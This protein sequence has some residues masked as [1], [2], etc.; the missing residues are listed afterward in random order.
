MRILELFFETLEE[1]EKLTVDVFDKPYYYHITTDENV[2]SILKNGL[3]CSK[4]GYIYIIDIT[5][6]DVECEALK[7]NWLLL[8]HNRSK[9]Y[10]LIKINSKGLT[11]KKEKD[12]GVY[13]KTKQ[14][15]IDKKHLQLYAVYKYKSMADLWIE[16]HKKR[17]FEY[18]ERQRQRNEIIL[19]VPPLAHK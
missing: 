12:W 18:Y 19:T 8:A 9:E 3:K 10:A 4:D 14:E 5:T 16:N 13:Y 17:M 11:S 15:V 7:A 6:D 2:D 1:G